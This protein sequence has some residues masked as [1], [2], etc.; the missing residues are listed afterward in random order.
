MENRKK[1]LTFAADKNE[2]MEGNHIGIF[3][4]LFPFEVG[5]NYNISKWKEYSFTTFKELETIIAELDDN[6]EIKTTVDGCNVSVSRNVIIREGEV[7]NTGILICRDVLIGD[8]TVRSD[9][10]LEDADIDDNSIIDIE[11]YNGETIN[12]A[13]GV[14][15]RRTTF[16]ENVINIGRNVPTVESVKMLRSLMILG[17]RHELHWYF[18]DKVHIG[19]KSFPIQKWLRDFRTIGSD[20][21]YTEREIEEY[22]R[23]ILF[24]EAVHNSR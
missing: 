8:A 17:T 15:N 23:Y 22:E 9:T 3:N 1:S 24:C 16:S 12:I 19:C 6:T 14:T 10:V 4:V 18:T 7:I 21:H 2:F 20:A 11:V 5:K 13:Y